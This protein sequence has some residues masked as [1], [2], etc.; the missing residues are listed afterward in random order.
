MFHSVIHLPCWMDLFLA[1]AVKFAISHHLVTKI[2]VFIWKTAGPLPSCGESD[3]DP[4]HTRIYLVMIDCRLHR[5]DFR[6]IGNISRAPIVSN[7]NAVK[8]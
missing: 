5:Y 2:Q 4:A 7:T 8:V 6:R 3:T 1:D